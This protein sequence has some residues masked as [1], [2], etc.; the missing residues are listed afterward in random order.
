MSILK[1]RWNQEHEQRGRHMLPSLFMSHFWMSCDPPTG[2]FCPGVKS[3]RRRCYLSWQLTAKLHIRASVVQ[4]IQTLMK[5]WHSQIFHRGTTERFGDGENHWVCSF[6][7][8]HPN[9]Y[10]VQQC[11]LV[12]DWII[13]WLGGKDGYV[14]FAGV[15]WLNNYLTKE[16]HFWPGVFSFPGYELR[17]SLFLDINVDDW[18][19]AVR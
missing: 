7:G 9:R 4:V 3:R 13:A 2:I 11:F 18:V 17:W 15:S 19:E 6:S 12:A 16:K 5:L 10:G 14:I 8:W 1:W